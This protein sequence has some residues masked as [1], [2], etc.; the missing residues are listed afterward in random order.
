MFPF[1]PPGNAELQLGPVFSAHARLH[2]ALLG[3]RPRVP[4]NSSM[5]FSLASVFA[6]AALI[7]I[8]FTAP[9][10]ADSLPSPILHLTFDDAT[11]AD[12][13]PS[14][15]TVTGTAGF[16]TAGGRSYATL[17]GTSNAITAGILRS[18]PD[19]LTISFWTL[20]QDGENGMPKNTALGWA[21][22]GGS[23]GTWG[24]GVL[25][26][27]G[28]N[29]TTKAIVRMGHENST[30]DSISVPELTNWLNT[31]VHWT[32]VKNPTAGTI[33][34]YRDGQ[35]YSSVSGRNI[36]PAFESQSWATGAGYRIGR[37]N[38]VYYKGYL[39]DYRIY[40]TALDAAQVQTV[41]QQGAAT[42]PTAFNVA[43]TGT[44]EAGQ[45]LTGTYQFISPTGTEGAST[46]RWYRADAPAGPFEPIAGATSLTYTAT[47]ADDGR[48]LV[49]GVTPV[50]S[51]GTVGDEALSAP[52][53][54]GTFVDKSLANTVRRLTHDKQLKVAFFGGS[55]T[56]G[57]GQNNGLPWRTR[58]Q[59]W[60]TTTYPETVFTFTNASISGTSSEFG[61]FRT[62]RHVL[63]AEPDLVFV[64]FAVNDLEQ[65]SDTRTRH[66]LEGIVRKIRAARP[67]CDIVFIYTTTRANAVTYYEA[68]QLPPRTAVH[69]GVAD[70]YD[71]RTI[72]VAAALV[73]HKQQ[74]GYPYRIEF[75]Q[76]G[77]F[78]PAANHYLPD[79][80][81]PSN[82]GH[83]VY[84]DTVIAALTTYL[85]IPPPAALKPH[86]MPALFGG[87]DMTSARI[88]DH[89]HP[90]VTHGAGWAV[91]ALGIGSG[92]RTD[93]FL[94][95][96]TASTASPITVSF[97]GRELGVYYRRSTSGGQI[98]WNV[99]AGA[100]SATFPFW[101]ETLASFTSFT[102]LA[103]DLADGNHTAVITPQPYQTHENLAIA[104]WLV[105]GEFA[106]R[107]PGPLRVLALGDSIT[108]GLYYNSGMPGNQSFPNGYRGRLQDLLQAD[109]DFTNHFEFIG[110]LT[111]NAAGSTFDPAYAP[112]QAPRYDGNHQG[113]SGFTTARN[114]TGTPGSTGNLRDV[115]INNYTAATFNPDIVLLHVGVNDVGQ[116]DLTLANITQLA[117]DHRLLIQTIFSLQPGAE[118]YLSTIMWNNPNNPN[119][120]KLLA[121]NDLLRTRELPYWQSQ[122][123]PVRLVDMFAALESTGYNRETNPHYDSAGGGDALHPNDTGYAAMAAAWY[124]ALVQP[125]AVP[126]PAPS[127]T[128]WA[129]AT[130]SHLAGGAAHPSAAPTALTS[131]GHPNLLAYALDLDPFSPSTEPNVRITNIGSALSL[132]FLRAAP[133]LTYEV[134]GSSDLATWTTVATNPGQ[135]GEEVTVTDP[136]SIN[137][138]RFLR[139]R[140]TQ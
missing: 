41:Y 42:A 59:N 105:L 103:T 81:H 62:D 117:D 76:P 98:A 112:M 121:F 133:D 48:Y 49:L 111:D 89:T 1:L 101:H 54:V 25:L 82:L 85:T 56:D 132:S 65:I 87:Y 7:S 61:V 78:D 9:L 69:Q 93:D 118:V 129:S 4:L 10:R 130:Y 24:D 96:S 32:V 115:V 28:W 50:N 39:D 138:R 35:P 113:H 66:T 6:L 72:D 22:Q 63:S 99:D 57:A 90:D 108:Y 21:R 126:A 46:F 44:P 107:S 139:L 53:L 55:I 122:G 16:A 106:P 27:F 36:I 134:L 12:S 110:T 77:A 11:L 31:W 5:R 47:S 91:Q 34:V 29:N 45:T 20:A 14:P 40:D 124:A 17:N 116:G 68:N 13:S 73:A 131:S 23:T 3:P 140:V 18:F 37:Y 125:A 19:G 74:T 92:G 102:L 123:K 64:E 52:F 119:Y 38:D 33:A 95:T 30:N 83:Q 136:V 86:P 58:V 135:V 128:R 137:P 79:H 26:A 70:H 88:I 114:Y 97:A 8:A 67:A 120:A 51:S 94:T 100:S 80:V 15:R 127:F 75:G 104:G 2:A 71:I 60:F 109:P 84:G 43:I